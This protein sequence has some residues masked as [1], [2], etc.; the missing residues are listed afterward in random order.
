MNGDGVLIVGGGLAGLRCAQTLRK[1][2]YDGPVRMVCAEDSAPYDRPPLSKSFLTEPAGSVDV[3][4]KPDS[5]YRESEI[6]LLLGRSATQLKADERR[7]I[8]DDGTAVP[9]GNLLIACGSGARSLTA[10]EGFENVHFLRDIG[11]A[12]RLGAELGTG[13]R[14][15]VIG[16]GFIGQE[17]ASS[18]LRLGD[19]VTIVEA[20][21]N[22]LEHI[23]G[24][25]VGRRIGELHTERGIS[26]LTDAKVESARGGAHVREL[27][28]A[29]GRRVP[30]ETVVVG[31]GVTP[32]T[33]WL[34]GSGLELDGI[35]TD[36][37]ARTCIP[38]VFAAGDVTRSYDPRTGLHSRSEHWGSAVQQGRAAALSMLGESS[39]PPGLPS[40]WSD[41]HG[42]RLQYVGHAEL[43]DRVEILTDGDDPALQASYLR[44]DR[45][46]GALAIDAPRVIAAAARTIEL[47]ACTT[48]DAERNNHEVQSNS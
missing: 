21:S 18:A 43:A 11:D 20:M 19:E 22:P 1:K 35:I 41:Q 39:P 14:L 13:G 12:R 5:W 3:S 31:V 44:G 6:E 33:G 17:V 15:A 26:L 10:L 29:D 32:A 23:L 9:Y 48:D 28:L 24:N 16:S 4:L 40:F 8:L 7:V 30:C 34:Q 42:S 46:V 27:R 2:G 37:A 38:G 45:L 36:A 25:E 47:S